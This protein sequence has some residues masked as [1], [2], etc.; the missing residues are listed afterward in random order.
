[1]KDTHTQRLKM[2]MSMNDE[3]REMNVRKKGKKKRQA[4]VYITKAQVLASCPA[5]FY[6]YKKLR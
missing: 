3:T 6:G 2:I 4:N 1:M 5:R